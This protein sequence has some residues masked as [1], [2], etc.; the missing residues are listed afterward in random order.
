[1]FGQVIQLSSRAINNAKP[2]GNDNSK[3]LFLAAEEEGASG[4]ETARVSTRVR[5]NPP[6]ASIAQIIALQTNPAFFPHKAF[7]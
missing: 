5:V 2:I 3:S 1:M 7:I 4:P 6:Q